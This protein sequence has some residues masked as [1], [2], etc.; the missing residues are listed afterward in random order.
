MENRALGLFLSAKTQF[1]NLGSQTLKQLAWVKNGSHVGNATMFDACLSQTSNQRVYPTP[2]F[3][4]SGIEIRIA[5]RYLLSTRYDIV[6]DVGDQKENDFVSSLRCH[7]SE[8]VGM[9]KKNLL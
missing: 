8:M 9:K 6:F 1:L 5:V 7:I 4:H 3:T 2:Q